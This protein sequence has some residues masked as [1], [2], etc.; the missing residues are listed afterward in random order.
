MNLR[1]EGSERFAPEPGLFRARGFWTRP[2]TE[3]DPLIDCNESFRGRGLI[4]LSDGLPRSD[5]G[6]RFKLLS[7]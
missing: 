1:L 7:S 4:I 5:A 2:G 3:S 6:V